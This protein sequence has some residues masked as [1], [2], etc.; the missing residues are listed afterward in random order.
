MKCL[1]TYTLIEIHDENPDFLNF[2]DQEFVIPEILMA[3]F[4]G[5]ILRDYNE[6]TADYLIKKFSAFIV[7]V[8]FEIMIKAMKYRHENKKQNLSFFDCVGYIFARENSMKFVTGDKE[9]EN[10]EGVEFIKG[11]KR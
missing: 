4:Y 1:D 7:P 5:V 11:I 2:L 3:E 6:K 8:S 9:F 10:K